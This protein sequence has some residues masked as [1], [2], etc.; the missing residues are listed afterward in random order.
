M[1][2]VANINSN[3]GGGLPVGLSPMPVRAIPFARPTGGGRHGNF[4]APFSI[5]TL[6]PGIFFLPQSAHTAGGVGD[7]KTCPLTSLSGTAA[8]ITCRRD[9]L[10]G[11]V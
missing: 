4:A 7:R 9:V 10:A 5:Q 11:V 6:R 8:G 3:L 2:V 1:S